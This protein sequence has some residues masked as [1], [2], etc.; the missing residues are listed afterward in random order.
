M[1]Q[2]VL[3]LAA[4]TTDDL[5]AAR[6]GRK[7]GEEPSISYACPM[8]LDEEEVV[9]RTSLPAPEPRFRENR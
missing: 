5:A 9:T 8:H 1:H 2:C 3:V 7:L 6:D 4:V